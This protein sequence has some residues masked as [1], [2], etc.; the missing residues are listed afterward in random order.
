MKTQIRTVKQVAELIKTGKTLLI[1]GDEKLLKQLPKGSWIAGTIPYLMDYSGGIFT[2]SELFITELPGYV[3]STKQVVY[4]D[5]SISSVYSDAY[6]NGFSVIIMPSGSDIHS[7]FS[8]NSGKYHGFANKPLVGWVSGINL[9]KAEY[10]TPKYLMEKPATLLPIR[11]WCYMP[12]YLPIKL[13]MWISST[14]LK[15]VPVMS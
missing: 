11:Q 2:E 14:Y 9:D 12:A 5:D 7:S 15:K 4:D 10:S 3:L 6:T 8:L 13:P 1:A